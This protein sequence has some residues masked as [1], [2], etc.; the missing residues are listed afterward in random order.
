MKLLAKL[1]TFKLIMKILEIKISKFHKIWHMTN[2][3]DLCDSYFM[4]CENI[5]R[6]K[7]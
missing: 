1:F 2:N 7:K 3:C 6:F 5:D 4:L